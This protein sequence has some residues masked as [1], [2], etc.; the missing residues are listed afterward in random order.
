MW[1][2]NQSKITDKVTLTRYS[3]DG[4]AETY[5][6]TEEEVD[7]PAQKPLFPR[8]SARKYTLRTPYLK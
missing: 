6:L 3:P 1:K 8:R 2:Q 7:T 4:L 5:N